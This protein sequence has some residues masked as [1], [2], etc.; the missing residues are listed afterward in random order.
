MAKTNSENINYGEQLSPN[1]DTL[2][3]YNDSL[4]KTNR[5]IK[6]SHSVEARRNSKRIIHNVYRA[7][8]RTV[9]VMLFPAW[10]FIALI[11]IVFFFAGNFEPVEDTITIGDYTYPYIR[12]DETQMYDLGNSI[13][14]FF[15]STLRAIGNMGETFK[16]LLVSEDGSFNSS[17]LEL[18]S[19]LVGFASDGFTTVVDWFKS[20]FNK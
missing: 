9:S 8:K 4:I 19:E 2:N 6:Q 10:T 18:V 12:P 11:T 20:I 1:R 7:S 14:N 13:W 17:L 16:D 3:Q 15:E 5:D